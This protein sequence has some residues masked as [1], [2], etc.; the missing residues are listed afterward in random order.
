MR[1]LHLIKPVMCILPEVASP[2]RKIPFR[3]KALW[4]VVTLFI[5]L[6]CC[7]IPLYG[8]A[9]SKSSDPF[10]WMRV[11]LASNR[12][13]LMELGISPIITS[14][15]VMQ[16]LAGARIIEVNQSLKEDRA[17]FAGA[18]KLFGILITIGEAIA[19]VVSGMYGDLNTLGAGNAILIILQLFTAGM[20]VII[21]DE[22]LQKG[23]GLGSGI[24][25]FIATNIC[26]SIIWKAFSPTTINTGRG[27]EFEGAL[28]ALIHLMITRQNKVRA[29]KEAFYRS[30]LPNLTNLIATVLIFLIVIYFQGW[31][32]DLPIKYA[33]FRGQQGK[34][35][36][37]LF[38]TSNMPIILQ[39]ALVSNLYFLSQLLYN[40][41]S[42]NILVRLLGVWKELKE[43]PGNSVPVSGL[44]Y[45]ISPPQTLADLAHDPLHA[46][47]YLIF[48]LSSCALFSKTWIEVSGS[49]PKDVAK[50]LRDQQLIL[51]GHRNNSIVH[52]L[53]R[54]IPAAA[55]FGGICIGL[56][57]VL[58]D[59]LGAIGSGTGIL[60][61]VTIIYQYYEMFEKVNTDPNAFVA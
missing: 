12:G 46:V 9:A 54:Y 16:L 27:T 59:F 33:K 36:I 49:S 51:K 45:Y 43:N 39:T 24:S 48:I 20:V 38:Y 22:L 42:G 41:Y 1:F 37:K 44:A 11:I 28:I 53:N 25:L 21:L 17:L 4:T 55:A 13:T 50:Q 57:T 14:G 58:A 61:A 32:V 35:P 8:I 6:V 31:R 2:D 56:L 7:Q 30:N 60:L 47:L 10:Y 3:E 26:E 40:R 18:Q 15:L 5:F 23:Y 19:Y 34:Y 29:L 52:E